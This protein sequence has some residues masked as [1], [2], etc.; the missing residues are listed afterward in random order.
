M[1]DSTPTVPVRHHLDKRAADLAAQG[2]GDPDDLLS[3]SDLAEWLGVSIQWVEIGRSK[4]WSPPFI[5]LSPRR[6]RYAARP[7]WNGCGRAA[8]PRPPST[9]PAMVRAAHARRRQMRRDPQ[10]EAAGRGPTT[11]PHYFDRQPGLG[12]GN[13]ATF[14]RLSRANVKRGTDRRLLA[15]VVQNEQPT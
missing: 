8:S 15:L 11:R 13:A 6:I 10:S 12:A 9:K 3:T 7:S 2:V 4:G 14:V 5:K 1:S